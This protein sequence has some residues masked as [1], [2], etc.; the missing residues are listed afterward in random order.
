MA[1]SMALDAY[2]AGVGGSIQIEHDA[3]FSIPPNGA[4]TA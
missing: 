2:A 1:C 4:A 3:A